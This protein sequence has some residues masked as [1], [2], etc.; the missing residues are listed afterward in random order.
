MIDVGLKFAL[1]PVGNVL[2]TLSA[3]FPV[4]PFSALTVICAWVLWPCL[5]D[6]FGLLG[7]MVKSGGKI[8]SET[9]AKWLSAPEEPVIVRE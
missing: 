1:K 6:W 7:E 3:T 5:V 4:N 9:E 2:V 8:V